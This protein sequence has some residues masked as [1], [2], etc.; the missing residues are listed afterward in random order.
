[1]T[2]RENN[3]LLYEI[4]W[5]AFFFAF[6][7]YDGEQKFDDPVTSTK[8]SGAELFTKTRTRWQMRFDSL[9]GD[10][11]IKAIAVD[12]KAIYLETSPLDGARLP[13]VL[14]ELSPRPVFNTAS[15]TF[16]HDGAHLAIISP[17]KAYAPN[18]LAARCLWTIPWPKLSQR[19]RELAITL[20]DTIYSK[21]A[22]LGAGYAGDD[23]GGSVSATLAD[24]EKPGLR[25]ELSM[26]QT[27][28]LEQRPELSLETEM[29]PEQVQVQRQ[30]LRQILAIQQRILRMDRDE[31]TAY[32][33]QLGEKEALRVSTFVLAGRIKDAAL[34]VGRTIEWKEARRVARTMLRK[35]A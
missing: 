13:D 12:D 30:E 18:G 23:D 14:S 8:C 15:R 17:D 7:K 4:L 19:Q 25:L 16:Q 1:M 27:L 24:Q 3:D 6:G 10:P 21:N 31:M 34:S 9:P 11:H 35:T 32:F 28:R 33:A 2:N 22:F 26:L 5:N 29:R 20:A